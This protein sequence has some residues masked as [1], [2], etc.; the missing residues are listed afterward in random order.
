MNQIQIGRF[1]ADCRKESNMTQRQIAE[2][3]GITNRAV[4]KWETGV[5]H[6]KGY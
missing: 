4:S 1:I 6:T 2:K 5:S 3:L